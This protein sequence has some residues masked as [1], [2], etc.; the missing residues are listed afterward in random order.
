MVTYP[1]IEDPAASEPRLVHVRS[2]AWGTAWPAGAPALC[3]ARPQVD[4]AW[5][6][7][8]APATCP[9]CLRRSASSVVTWLSTSRRIAPVERWPAVQT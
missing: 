5:L 6:L 9:E 1:A 8:S 2:T 7:S 3:G 4:C